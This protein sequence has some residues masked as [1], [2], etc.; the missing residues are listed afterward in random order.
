[1]RSPRGSHAP[2][3]RTPAHAA[4]PLRH[5]A[6]PRDGAQLPALHALAADLTHLV[7]RRDHRIVPATVAGRDPGPGR[8]YA[9]TPAHFLSLVVVLPG[10]FLDA[11]T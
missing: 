6:D 3:R 7:S 5:F 4:E 11:T 8:R 2:V 9:G 10:S 1:M